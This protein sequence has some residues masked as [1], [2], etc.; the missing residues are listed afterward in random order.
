MVQADGWRIK[1]IFVIPLAHPLEKMGIQDDEVG[2]VDS[3]EKP[4]IQTEG[5]NLHSWTTHY[6]HLFYPHKKT[7]TFVWKENSGIFAS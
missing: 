1:K 3:D 6:Y 5:A 4:H 7:W 2:E